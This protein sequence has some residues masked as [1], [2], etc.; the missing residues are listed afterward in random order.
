[1]P[2]TMAVKRV[3]PNSAS[4]G[5]RY[6]NAGIVWPASSSGLM[7]R[8]AVLLRAIQTPK[9]SASTITSRVATSVMFSTTIVS[10]HRSS[11]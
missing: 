11:R 10:F 3:G 6:T 8:S 7:T 9:T 4:T 2:A 1:M 5:M